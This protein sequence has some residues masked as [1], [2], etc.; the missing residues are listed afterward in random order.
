MRLDVERRLELDE[1][2]SHRLLE[3]CSG[4]IDRCSI[5]VLSDYAK[6]VLSDWLVRRLIDLARG[7]GVP[8]LVD[9]KSRDIRRYAAASV[10]KPNSKEAAAIVGYECDTETNAHSAA[11]SICDTADIAGVVLTRGAQGMTIWQ[12]GVLPEPVQVASVALDVFDVSGA[13]DTVMAT[14]ALALAA[15]ADLTS[16]AT[17]ANVAA[18]VVVA[19]QGT[20]VV[21][22]TEL[23]MAVQRQLGLERPKAVDLAEATAIVE[24]WR[25]SGLVVG[26]TNGCFDLVHAGHVTL[27][28][29]ARQRCDRLIVAI[30]SDASVRRL[31]GP[32]R[33]VQSE[34]GRATVLAAMECVDMIVQFD[35]DTPLR[36][37]QAL[38][39]DRLI[40]GAEYAIDQVVGADVVQARGGEVLLIPLVAGNSTTA[41]IERARVKT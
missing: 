15:G 34:A 20:A 17:L 21:T 36:L 25:K 12:P 8:V 24:V 9:P 4:L 19:H 31:K 40:K 5:V 1:P 6:G 29:Q 32:S 14:L 37:I 28:K 2:T 3:I 38:Q 23:A 11:R 7:K 27:L 22:P 39:P 13:G 35:D 26:F 30:N 10:I 41:L 18:G 33:P 16:A